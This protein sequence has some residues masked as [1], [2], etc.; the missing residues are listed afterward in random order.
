MFAGSLDTST[1]MTVFGV[2]LAYDVGIHPLFG[3]LCLA[4]LSAST[5]R[6]L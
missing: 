6:E 3:D 4:A 1:R 2:G 5:D